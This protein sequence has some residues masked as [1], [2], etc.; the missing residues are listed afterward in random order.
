MPLLRLAFAFTVFVAIL[1]WGVP[2]A[3]AAGGGKDTSE[4]GDSDDVIAVAPLSIP[5]IKDAQVRGFLQLE[6]G[7]IAGSPEMHRYIEAA[8]PRLRDAY[9]RNM[10]VFATN[11]LVVDRVPDLT[12]VGQTLQAITDHTLQSK[13]AT[14]L[15]GQIMVQQV[16]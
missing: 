3:V 5:I 6:I 13:G 11:H 8:M 14:V 2:P 10:N 15:F 16:Q 12:A 4:S 1:S 9:I 7:L